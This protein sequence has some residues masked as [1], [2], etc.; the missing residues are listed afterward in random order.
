[1]EL[2]KQNVRPRDI[3]T[4]HAFENAIAVDMAIG[5]S[6]NTALHLPKN[7]IVRDGDAKDVRS[8]ILEGLR[9]TAHGF[10]VDNPVFIPDLRVNPGKEV[11][12]LDLVSELRPKEDSE[13]LFM[14]QEILSRGEPVIGVG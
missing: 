1:V 7:P 2:L 8:E 11:R 9:T 6:T 5:G 14:D 13:R 10:T 12:F 3:L 4:K